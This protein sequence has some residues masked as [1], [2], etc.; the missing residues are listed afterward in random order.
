MLSEI[1]CVVLSLKILAQTVY[2]SYCSGMDL[3]M[4]D[5]EDGFVE[6]C[7]E[8]GYFKQMYDRYGDVKS[9]LE[10]EEKIY[11]R[12]STAADADQDEFLTFSTDLDGCV[13]ELK[14][15]RGI[16][17]HVRH[18]KLLPNGLVSVRRIFPILKKHLPLSEY[19]KLQLQNLKESFGI[20]IFY[21]HGWE[22][23]L[24]VVPSP[25]R[26]CIELKPA[27]L[28]RLTFGFCSAVKAEFGR[29]L[30]NECS[31]GQTIRKTLMKNDLLNI[32]TLFVLHDDCRQVLCILQESVDSCLVDNVLQPILFCFRF[33]EKCSEGVSLKE[34]IPYETRSVTVHSAVDISSPVMELLWSTAGLQSVIGSRGTL[35]TCATFAECGNYQSHLD[36][37]LLDVSADL[38]RVCFEPDKMRFVQFYADLPHRKPQRRFHPVSGCIAGGM[39]FNPRTSTAYRKDAEAYISTLETNFRLLNTSSCRLEFVTELTEF[40]DVVRATDFFDIK[41]LKDLLESKPLLVPFPCGTMTCTQEIGLWCTHE[42]KRL[43]TQ[44]D[45]TGNVECVWQAFQHELAVEKLLWGFPLCFKSSQYSV[46]LGPG[47][48]LPS[49]KQNR[50]LP[51]SIWTSSEV[52]AGKMT[53]CAGVHDILSSSSYVIGRRLVDVLIRDLN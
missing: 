43:L 36:G 22:C 16:N 23:W 47:K 31:S 46:N 48:L 28:K 34:Y 44:Y 42:L 6:A 25:S 14:S 20:Q 15:L 8:N 45:S 4:E 5:E 39:T 29:R 11:A 51:C 32:G 13:V 41:R 50:L 37:K 27:V 9:F 38:R 18:L 52:V 10:R 26:S 21:E 2:M 33:G 24:G 1:A 30:R 53:R 19:T 17:W 3:E 35:S 7:F 40:K 49:R 12:S